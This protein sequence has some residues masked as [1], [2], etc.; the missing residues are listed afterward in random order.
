M[1]AMTKR[2]IP[3]D[4]KLKPGIENYASASIKGKGNSKKQDIAAAIKNEGGLGAKKK[5]KK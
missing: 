3:S 2:K 4:T 1:M 5:K